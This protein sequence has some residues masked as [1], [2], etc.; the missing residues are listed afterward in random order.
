MFFLCFYT[1]EEIGALGQVAGALA[2]TAAVLV[3]LFWESYQRRRRAPRLSISWRERD[4]TLEELSPIEF[5]KWPRLL[6]L[7]EGKEAAQ[8]VEIVASDLARRDGNGTYTLVTDFI[9]TPLTWTHSD[10]SVCDYLPA[11]ADRLCDLG[12]YRRDESMDKKP[13]FRFALSTTPSTGYD[14]LSPGSYR[15]RLVA[16]ALNCQP[17]TQVLLIRVGDEF[18][19]N[20]A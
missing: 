12:Y 16:T 3:A 20:L 9:P 11:G 15:V 2:T 6:I 8:R 7:N 10:S 18:S 4:T 13:Y 19:I 14:Y 5:A 17:A 1:W